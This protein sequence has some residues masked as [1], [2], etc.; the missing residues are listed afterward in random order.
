MVG[1]LWALDREEDGLTLRWNVD[2]DVA[3]AAGSAAFTFCGEGQAH[4]AD[5]TLAGDLAWGKFFDVNR[6]PFCT[7]ASDRFVFRRRP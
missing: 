6:Q 2:C 3:D 4:V 1:A 7:N 5:G